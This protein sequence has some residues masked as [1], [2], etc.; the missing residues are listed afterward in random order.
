MIKSTIYQKITNTSYLYVFDL[1]TSFL[2]KNIVYETD[3]E[4]TI[5][6]MT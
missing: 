2:I 4:S 5:R 1:F 6:M 3:H